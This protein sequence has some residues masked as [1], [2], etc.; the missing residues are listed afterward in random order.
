MIAFFV[1]PPLLRTARLL[2]SRNPAL[3]S[4]LVNI[5][6]QTSFLLADL[7][8]VQEPVDLDIDLGH[9]WSFVLRVRR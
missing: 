6:Q 2:E 4:K 3:G 9:G 7:A 8:R 5:L 1:R